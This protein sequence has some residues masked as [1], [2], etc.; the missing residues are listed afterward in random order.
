MDQ[1]KKAALE[2][3]LERIEKD[4]GKGAVM[5]LGEISDRLGTDAI[6]TEYLPAVRASRTDPLV[7]LR[8][9]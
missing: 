4:H 2:T 9:E 1:D 3:A 7:A 8:F 5:R 6:P